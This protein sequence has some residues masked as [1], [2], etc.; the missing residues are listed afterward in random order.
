MWD[1]A[2]WGALV[3]AT[4]AGTATLVL[5]VVRAREAWRGLRRMKLDLVRALDEV[6]AKAGV[7]AEKV[8][9][10][11]DTAEV[12]EAVGR[13]RVSLARLAVLRAALS[14]AQLTFGRLTALVPR[15]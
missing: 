1:W 9:A 14:D 15:A 5:L 4:A 2:I 8:A 12:A 11:G 13:L 3:L 7:T 10:A 6:G